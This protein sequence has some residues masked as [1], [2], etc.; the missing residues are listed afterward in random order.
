MKHVPCDTFT[1]IFCAVSTHEKSIHPA[2]NLNISI[3]SKLFFVIV[4][5]N[6]CFTGGKSTKLHEFTLFYYQIFLQIICR[7][8]SGKKNLTGINTFFKAHI[9]QF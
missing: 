2:Y 8:S 5:I 4:K 1:K 6:P 9:L 3:S 7:L